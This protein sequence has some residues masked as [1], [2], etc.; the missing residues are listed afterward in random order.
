MARMTAAEKL[1]LFFN[2]ARGTRAVIKEFI[3]VSKDKYGTYGYS[4]GY[5]ESLLVD[6]IM[7]LPKARREAYRSQLNNKAYAISQEITNG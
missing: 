7:E 2:E 6:V 4:S 1:D 3:D 5:L